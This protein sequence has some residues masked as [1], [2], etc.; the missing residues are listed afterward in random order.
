MKPE[1]VRYRNFNK[2]GL[3]VGWSVSQLVEQTTFRVFDRLKQNI[4]ALVVW[5]TYK[6]PFMAVIFQFHLSAELYI[7]YFFIL[8]VICITNHCM[9]F[10]F[11]FPPSPFHQHYWWTKCAEFWASTCR[12]TACHAKK[13][14]SQSFFSA[15]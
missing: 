1:G 4:T 12:E 15:L 6:F 2:V 3:L 9:S 8:T 13:V 5:L 14:W 11:F 10:V 7:C